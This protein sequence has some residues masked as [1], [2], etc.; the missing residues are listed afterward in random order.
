MA[1][2][3]EG[4]TVLQTKIVDLAPFDS[5]APTLGHQ[6]LALL[7]ADGAIRLL[8]TNWDDCL[9]R[10][11]QEE[12]RILAARD[13][14][15]AEELRRPHVLKIHGCCSRPP[16]LLVTTE[17]L[18]DPPLW[19]KSTFSAEIKA[20]TVVFVGVGDVAP[21]V[22]EPI[23]ELSAFIDGARVRVVSPSI[24]TQWET[25]QWK[26]V[27]PD[28][29]PGRRIGATADAFV[30]ELARGWLNHLVRELDNSGQPEWITACHAAF[31]ALTA[32]EA[33]RWLRRAATDW[34]IGESVVRS[35]EAIAG[36]KAIAV[37]AK[38]YISSSGGAL[39]RFQF[40]PRAAVS[41]HEQR[42]E[43][44]IGRPNQPTTSLERAARE[45][46]ENVANIYGTNMIT[47]LCSA[48]MP[49]GKRR[50]EL[51]MVDVLAGDPD[52][53][54]LITGPGQA[55]IEL[56]WADDLLKAS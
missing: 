37:L 52:P 54:D 45:R 48:S 36:L 35:T 21:Y 43:V 7:L 1:S 28:L 38:Q 16:T 27:L 17:Q 15:E 2:L 3:P 33:L 5:V 31:G 34:N 9:E 18:K 10:G 12:G 25:S 49:E 8:T 40:E 42:I 19:T 26:D 11:W 6:L 23:D 22:R 14:S 24:V 29:P 56:L 41:L 46:A 13:A 39:S 20:S 53:D 30:D 32:I 47:V 50:S 44:V 4:L 55:Q 51:E